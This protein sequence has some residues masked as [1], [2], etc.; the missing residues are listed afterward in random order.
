M[1]SKKTFRIFSW[2]VILSFLIG[3]V[4][5]AVFAKSFKDTSNH[6]A[7]GVIDRWANTYNVANGYLD[8]T[9]KPSGMI[10]RAEFAQLVSKVTG[11]ALVKPEINFKDVKEN[12]WFYSA[13]R[14][15]A[16]YINGYPDGT[17]KPKNNITREEAACLLAKVFGIDKLQ[18]NIL[19][20]FSDYNQVSSWAKEYLTAMVENGYMQ[21]YAD[22]SLK[23]KNY[24]TRAVALTILDNIVGLLLFKKGV[25]VGREVRGNLVINS[26]GVSVS[27]FSIDKNCLITEGVKDGDVTIAGTQVNGS[28]IV[29]GGG[30]HSVVLKDVKASSIVVVN[31]QATTRIEISGNSKIE[32]IVVEKPA[33]ILVAEKA[34]VNTV[35]IRAD[36]TVL[37]AEGKIEK[38]EVNAKDV[39]VNNKEVKEGSEIAVGNDSES[40]GNTQSTN[41]N[42]SQ[43]L[44]QKDTASQASATSNG[45]GAQTNTGTSSGTAN[46]NVSSGFSTGGYTGGGSTSSGGSSGS[47]AGVQYGPVSVVL[48]DKETIPVGQSTQITVTVKDAAGNFIPNK[49]VMVEGQTAYTNALGA[50]TF[51]LSVQDSKEIV[52]NVDGKEYYGLLYAIKPTEGVLTFKLKSTN[53]SFLSGFNVKLVNQEKQFSESKS[54]ASDQVSFIVPAVGGYKALIWSYDNQNGLIYTILDNLSVGNGVVR[55]VADTSLPQYI[56]ATLNFSLNSQPLSN[57]EFAIANSLNMDT[58][59]IDDVKINILSNQIRI[60][61][62]AGSYSFK[63]AT[64]TQDGKLYFMRNLTLQQS[65]QSFSFNFSSSK[66]VKFNFAGIDS[67]QKSV[68][69]KLNG[70]W[71]ELSSENEVYLQRGVYNLEEVLI[72]AYDSDNKEIDYSYKIPAA[73]SP[74]VIDATGGNE[75]YEANVD[76][77]IDDVSSSVYAVNVQGS[78]IS[79]I[80]AGSLIVLNALLR[81]K[82]GFN[83]S[84]SKPDE[85]KKDSKQLFGASNVSATILTDGDNCTAIETLF[86]WIDD[87]NISS[88]I[89]YL[90]R[91]LRDGS[92]SLKYTID[93]GPLYANSLTGNIALSIDSQNGDD[94]GYVYAQN[95]I[96]DA[97]YFVCDSIDT[98]AS[99]FVA[100]SL[101]ANVDC[102]LNELGD[103]VA[104]ELMTQRPLAFEYGYY[105]MFGLSFNL[106]NQNLFII[107]PVYIYSK[108]EGFARR[109]AVEQKAWQVVSTVIDQTYNDYDKVLALHDWLALHTRYDLEGYLNNDVPYESHTAYGALINGVAVCN[110]YATGM[111]ALLEDADVETIEIY[112]MAGIGSSKEYHAWN[113]VYLEDNWYHLDVT[114]D[115]DDYYNTV[116]HYYF[117]VP[118]TE[119]EFDHYWDRSLYPAATATDYSYGNYYRVEVVPK[120]VYYNEDNTVTLTVKNYKGELQSGKLVT[121]T[122]S[123]AAGDEEVVFTGYTSSDGTVAFNVK[124]VDMSSYRIYL[125]SCMENKGYIGVVEKPKPVTL[126]LNID[127]QPIDNFY[128]SDGLNFLKVAGGVRQVELSRWHENNLIFWGEGFVLKKSLAFDSYDPETLTVYN[129][130]YDSH[131]LLSVYNSTYAAADADV[132]VIDKNTYKEL[133]VGRTDSNGELPLVLTNGN[134]ILKIAYYNPDY[135]NYDYYY[136]TLKVEQDT[137]I[138]LDLSQFSEVQYIPGFTE[139]GIGMGD[140]LL[141]G[142]DFD[143]DGYFAVSSIGKSR[144]A[145]FAPGDYGWVWVVAHNPYYDEYDLGFSMEYKPLQKLII[146]EDKNQYTV[147]LRVDRSNIVLNAKRRPEGSWDSVPT[148]LDAVYE[149]DDLL[150]DIYIPTKSE[151]YIVG[152]QIVPQEYIEDNGDMYII[153]VSTPGIYPIRTFTISNNTQNE[154][155]TGHIGFVNTTNS[156]RIVVL[157]VEGSQNS[158]FR[159]YLPFVPYDFDVTIDREIVIYPVSTGLGGTRREIYIQKVKIF[160]QVIKTQRFKEIKK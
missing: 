72:K 89:A 63:V 93:M 91:E 28:I 18:S 37:Q 144:R 123:N 68:Y 54:V 160:N 104:F 102:D 128:I 143:Y 86:M 49:R 74:I 90:P 136:S 137:Q 20:K 118:D 48:V 113:M 29:R 116:E 47:G 59:A 148:T 149:K 120:Q 79:S 39:V 2:V 46:S 96:S 9:F 158:I 5:P 56:Q 30:E 88:T 97:V 21:G 26:P 84:V 70:N 157:D 76:L 106:K 114:W 23:P 112:G 60:T 142:F 22:N 16:D 65:G 77:S 14:N 11:D 153:W 7:K 92:V 32:R 1:S 78:E 36:R 87:D 100:F 117:N 53:G 132:Y 69:A 140:K 119:I 44:T 52:I 141:L 15:L 64:D 82:S 58:F 51:T 71:I 10:T 80:K 40:N 135:D 151:N 156:W 124:P 121:I 125:T 105:D 57:Y 12:D 31:K 145:Y 139:G 133:F 6:W 73:N 66:K 147:D 50:A 19:S 134:Y 27:G 154:L 155:F 127:D 101:P 95:T 83:L 55:L 152:G 109:Q 146:P 33:S 25:Y 38:V 13:V 107:L 138:Q 85:M 35:N 99:D 43:Q 110:G 45:S 126:G 61:A 8:G 130:T 129:D 159:I 42:T 4:N 41:N 131:V 150:I 122:K 24:I 98:R 3:F 108:E 94:K 34:S 115:D 62:D 75:E 111:L 67:V 103:E 81:T 17:F